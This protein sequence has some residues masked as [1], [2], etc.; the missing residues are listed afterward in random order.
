[1]WFTKRWKKQWMSNLRHLH[2]RSELDEA[3]DL[4]SIWTEGLTD[5][6]VARHLWAN[7]GT[8]TMVRGLMSREE[9]S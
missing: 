1:M 4:I 7:F 5:D 3:G 9:S 8:H 2:G 6:L